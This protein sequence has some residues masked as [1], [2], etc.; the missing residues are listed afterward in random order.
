MSTLYLVGLGLGPGDMSPLAVEMVGRCRR[1]FCE[2]YTSL[3]PALDLDE[4]KETLGTPVQRLN[5]GRVEGV[6]IL[7]NALETGDTALLV[8]GDPMISTTHITLRVAAA[9]SGHAS[10]IIH[11][12]SIMSAAIGESCLTATRFGRMATVS[13]MRSKQPYDVL[14]DNRRA[15]LHTLFLL[16]V[17]EEA[18]RYM[19]VAQALDSLVSLEEEHGLGV[20]DD[21]TVAIGMARLG[22]EDQVV[23]AGSVAGLLESDLGPPPHCLAIPGDVHFSEREALRAVLG[24]R[25]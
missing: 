2:T 9:E 23:E 11:S 3:I 18:G 12:S 13:F 20:I 22:S 10:R 21:A 17:D 8:P 6:E 14:A 19:S 4:L 1:T 25:I 5:R 7:L 16:D 15:G 24:A